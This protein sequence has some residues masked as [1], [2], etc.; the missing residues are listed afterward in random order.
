MSNVPRSAVTPRLPNKSSDPASALTSRCAVAQSTTVDFCGATDNANFGNSVFTSDL[1]PALRAGWGVRPGDWQIGASIQ[2]QLLP[3]VSVEVGYTRR[4]LD[5]FTVV[6]NVLTAATDY[7]TFSVTA[8]TDT[9]LPEEAR[10][11]VAGLLA[12][13]AGDAESGGGFGHQRALRRA[14]RNSGAEE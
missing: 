7:S 13:R 14:S 3:R 12:A 6:D 10:G 4:W 1:D 8:P 2:Q 11:R 9:R 5:N